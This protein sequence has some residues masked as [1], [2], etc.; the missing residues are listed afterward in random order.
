MFLVVLLFLGR[1][2]GR[3]CVRFI[4]AENYFSYFFQVPH[5]RQFA[6]QHVTIF[7]WFVFHFNFLNFFPTVTFN[8]LLFQVSFFLLFLTSYFILLNN[9]QPKNWNFCHSRHTRYSFT[10]IYFFKSQLV[11]LLSFIQKYE[12]LFTTQSSFQCLNLLLKVLSLLHLSLLCHCQHHTWTYFWR[13]SPSF[14]RASM[15]VV[16]SSMQESRGASDLIITMNKT[17]KRP[18]PSPLL[19]RAVPERMYSFPQET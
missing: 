6:S 14:Q 10:Q 5:S 4:F 9:A 13:F 3:L 1:Q 15:I 19:I 18:G 7:F 17:K 2:S 16:T 8:L 11:N 12:L